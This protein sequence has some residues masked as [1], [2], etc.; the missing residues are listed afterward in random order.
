MRAN[1]AYWRGSAGDVAEAARATEEVLAELYR[2]LGPTTPKPL[3]TRNDLAHWRGQ[4][5]RAPEA[6]SR[7]NEPKGSVAS[8]A[9]SG[10]T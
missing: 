3:A 1:L 8:T 10:S 9:S 6:P 5:G 4:A 2:V 7:K